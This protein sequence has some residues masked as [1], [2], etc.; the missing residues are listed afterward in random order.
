MV[1]D[2]VYDVLMAKSA[3]AAAIGVAWG[4]H[5]PAALTAA[6]AS[7]IVDSFADLVV[8]LRGWP[9]AKRRGRRR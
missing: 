6:G 1:G 7:R 9:R 4:Y 3:G 8:H 2:T 5:P